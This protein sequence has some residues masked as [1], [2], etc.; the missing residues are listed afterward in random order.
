[1]SASDDGFGISTLPP[2]SVPR[3]CTNAQTPAYATA[4]PKNLARPLLREHNPPFPADGR[5]WPIPDPHNAADPE[6]HRMRLNRIRGPKNGTDQLPARLTPIFASNAISGPLPGK[7]ANRER[8]LLTICP[9]G[10][11]G[12]R[13]AAGAGPGGSDRSAKSTGTR[14]Y[15]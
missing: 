14:L 11:A 3:K 12:R 1:M 4:M 8:A 9:F 15:R 6:T 5:F 2:E 7:L 10:G 13:A